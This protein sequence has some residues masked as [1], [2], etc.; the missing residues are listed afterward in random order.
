MDL[1][2]EFTKYNIITTRYFYTFLAAN[3]KQDSFVKLVE[4]NIIDS[5]VFLRSLWLTQNRLEYAGI[6]VSAQLILFLG[7][8]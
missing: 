2:G 6:S 5:N 7:V 3:N 4:S 8:A 1:M